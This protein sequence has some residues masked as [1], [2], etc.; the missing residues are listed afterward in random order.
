M[1]VNERLV[2]AKNTKD[3]K[4]DSKSWLFKRKLII[5]IISHRS[6]Y[7]KASRRLYS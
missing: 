2:E 3:K 6:N 1:R 4:L 7:M 5:K